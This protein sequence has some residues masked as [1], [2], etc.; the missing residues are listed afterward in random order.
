MN[1]Y[2]GSKGRLSYCTTAEED[3]CGFIYNQGAVILI[4]HLRSD[5]LDLQ[6]NFLIKGLSLIKKKFFLGRRI[7]QHV[8]SMLKIE[9]FPARRWIEASY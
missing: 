2:D 7:W 1:Y 6:K 3:W 4:H 8:L 5:A 9:N